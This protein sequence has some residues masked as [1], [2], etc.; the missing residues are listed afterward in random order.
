MD[1]PEYTELEKQRMKDRF[2]NLSSEERAAVMKAYR[3]MSEPLPVKPVKQAITTL[4]YKQLAQNYNKE[5][6]NKKNGKKIK[7][8]TTLR[9]IV[10]SMNKEKTQIRVVN[11]PGSTISSEHGT[12]YITKKGKS[13]RIGD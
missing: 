5:E 8:E 4:T 3:A 11:K 13:I 12:F 2:L 10:R 1:A 6:N 7:V 9:K